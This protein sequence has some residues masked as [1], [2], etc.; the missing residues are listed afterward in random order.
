M[1]R[2]IP[3]SRFVAGLRNLPE[4]KMLGEVKRYYMEIPKDCVEVPDSLQ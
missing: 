3:I 1:A 2:N 4:L